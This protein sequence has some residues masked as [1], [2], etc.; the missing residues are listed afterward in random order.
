MNLQNQETQIPPDVTD[1]LLKLH[2]AE[3]AALTTRNNNWVTI[4]L[5]IWSVIILYLTAAVGAWA[6]FSQLRLNYGIYIVWGSGAVIQLTIA[7]LYFTIGEIYLNVYYIES[8][9]RPLVSN[10]VQGRPFWGYEAFLARDSNREVMDWAATAAVLAALLVAAL[11]R[12]AFTNRQELVG[13]LANLPLSAFLVWRTVAYAKLRK[14][15]QKTGHA[16]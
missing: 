15:F 9:L 13:L 7:V 3:Y 4:Q 5:G 1:S 6:Y 2:I 16:T 10:L 8:R 14:R 11:I 12:H